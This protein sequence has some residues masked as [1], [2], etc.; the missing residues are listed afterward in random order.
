[1][2]D[3]TDAA[4]GGARLFTVSPCATSL[5]LYSLGRSQAEAVALVTAIRKI[6]A[7]TERFEVDYPD[8][9]FGYGTVQHDALPVFFQPTLILRLKAEA[10]VSVSR[11]DDRFEALSA[12]LHIYD[13]CLSVL[14]VEWDATEVVCP[15][16]RFDEA[17]TGAA[18]S[19]FRDHI[20]GALYEIQRSL[21][22]DSGAM[23]V[24]R[25]P[26]EYSV[27]R[28]ADELPDAPIWT[29]R[30]MIVTGDRANAP[31]LAG[32]LGGL[33]PEPRELEGAQAWIGSGNS[34]FAVTTGDPERF[35][36]DWMRSMSLCQFYATL[37]NH[38]QSLLLS[39][40][41]MLEHAGDRDIKKRI[42]Q[43]LERKLDH[44][45]FIRLQHERA[46]YGLQG[47]RRDLV[48]HTHE[49]WQSALQFANV[50][51]WAALLRKQIDR[52]YR[53]RQLAQTRILKSIVAAIGGFSLFDLA[54]VLVNESR[55]QQGDGVVGIL[56]VFAERSADT[57]LYFA[58]AIL[59]VLMLFTYLS[60]K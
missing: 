1:M 31:P 2:K 15:A 3:A 10:P 14:F 11:R 42:L 52:Y 26:D 29:A 60:E 5:N 36:F 32:C 37:L 17:Y 53:R 55:S 16:S 18:K 47:A 8:W 30:A 27:F 58:V 48:R 35:A 6:E 22:R 21:A 28:P 54:I 34:L 51:G 49:A 20:L 56:D 25:A 41:R 50:E 57:V 40:V 46:L 9:P 45:D 13:D 4:A 43:T 24:L 12:E 19:L 39:E 59:I 38:Y 33:P 7:V 44:L 23:K